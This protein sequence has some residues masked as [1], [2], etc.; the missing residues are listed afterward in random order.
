VSVPVA[1]WWPALVLAL[2]AVGA[3]ATIGW[4]SSAARGWRR[5]LLLGCSGV[6]ALSTLAFV[7]L[8]LRGQTLELQLLQLTPQTWIALRVDAVGVLYASTAAWLWL[9]ALVYAFDYL[10]GPHLPRV[11]ATLMACLA[12]AMGVAF[13]GNLLTF[14]VFYE[15]L[16][17]LTYV[18][19][20][21]EQTPAA[22]AAGLKYLAYVLVGGSLVLCGVLL[23]FATSGE[24]TFRAG[25]LFGGDVTHAGLLLTFACF[26]LGFG[27]KAAVMPLH[28]WVPDAHP[29]APAPCSA[30]LSG[31]LVA[32]G[33]F[34]LVRVSFEVFGVA[35]LRE[36]AV[37]PVLAA[38]ASVSVVIAALKALQQ[39]DLKR[40]L[41]YSTISQMGYLTLALA[42]L[43]PVATVGALVH[44]VHHAFMKGALFFCAGSFAHATGRRGMAS[45]AGLGRRAPLTAAAFTLAA[46]GM[47]GVPP[48]SGFIG[49]WWLGLGMLDSP[50]PY[51]LVVLLLGALLAAGYLLPVVYSLYFRPATS[52]APPEPPPSAGRATPD[53]PPG[54]VLATGVA[55]ALTVVLGLAAS[56]PGFPMDLAQRAASQFFGGP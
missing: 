14:F 54:R 5:P 6:T 27:V 11:F 3:L 21:H 15:L 25:G 39:D 52:E 22:L 7:V 9:L 40:R 48:L 56:A 37:M 29:A 19:V 24:L 23:T 26:A 46:L 18:L 41:A 1:S 47:I 38:L 10:H 30:L 2:P 42:L 49:K 13:A 36:L 50:A 55:A 16:S 31:V 8:V 34:G 44:L 4:R 17:V 53:G 32:A 33:A 12:A 35:L 28:G 43:G 20:V 51:T 45:L